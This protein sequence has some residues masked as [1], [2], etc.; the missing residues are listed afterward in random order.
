MS[1]AQLANDLR[2]LVANLETDFAELHRIGEKLAG[3]HQDKMH[4][5]DSHLSCA[6]WYA[7]TLLER[8]EFAVQQ[9]EVR[10]P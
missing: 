1:N 10:E 4:F 7:R 2:E 3:R 5:A 9:E 8:V 6:L